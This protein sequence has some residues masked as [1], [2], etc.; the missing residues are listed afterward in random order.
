MLERAG[1]IDGSPLSHRLD[2]L[3]YPLW[4]D[5]RMFDNVPPMSDLSPEEVE[6]LRRSVAMMPAQSP[7]ML[8]RELLL[9][10]LAQLLRLIREA[11]QLGR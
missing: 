4:R 1:C 11:R 10:V 8:T 3:G 9:R 5:E 7:V 2:L 6:R